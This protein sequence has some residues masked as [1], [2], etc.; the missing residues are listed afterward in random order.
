MLLE[1]CR[2]RLRRLNDVVHRPRTMPRDGLA[3]DPSWRRA[4]VGDKLNAGDI[5]N[6]IVVVAEPKTS[7][8]EAAARMREQHVGCLVVVET[9]GAR[10]AVAGVL[11][12]RDIVTAVGAKGLDPK[13]LRVEDVIAG[14]VVT[15][16]ES[17]SFADLL[18]TMQRKGLRRLPVT[19]SDGTLV[20]LVTLDD[21]LNIVAEQMRTVVQV[22]EAGQRHE[23]I[24]RR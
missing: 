19:S 14:E 22:I 13:S 4:M 11:T 16:R 1:A 10:R 8:L 23:R 12:D 3:M 9:R 15:V 5:C 21:V 20:G 7:L 2:R 6:R 17:E 24:Q 18:A